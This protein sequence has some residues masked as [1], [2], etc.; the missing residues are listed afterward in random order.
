[1][2]VKIKVAQLEVEYIPSL[3]DIE[4]SDLP[5]DGAAMAIPASTVTKM[6]NFIIG[7]VDFQ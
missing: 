2:S 1:M 7:I 3:S 6:G 5:G 4:R